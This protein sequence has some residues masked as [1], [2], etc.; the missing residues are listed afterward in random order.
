MQAVLSVQTAVILINHLLTELKL[1]LL[2]QVV[3][4]VL[5]AVKLIN[6]SLI[7]LKLRVRLIL[8]I[9]VL[10]VALSVFQAA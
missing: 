8:I 2:P 4:L 6:A 3:S 1:K 7:I 5:Q 10:L 9:M